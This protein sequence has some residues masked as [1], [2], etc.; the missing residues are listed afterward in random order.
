M[1]DHTPYDRS[2]YGIVMQRTI[3]GIVRK[4]GLRSSYIH[5]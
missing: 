3:L 5:F 4:K 2:E 1:I